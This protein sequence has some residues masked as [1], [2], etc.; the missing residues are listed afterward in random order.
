LE[1]YSNIDDIIGKY[2][3]GEASPEDAMF[4]EEWKSADPKQY[5][6]FQDLSALYNSKPQIA[7]SD[8]KVETA[9]ETLQTRIQF[10]PAKKPANKNVL[11]WGLAA[12]VLLVL[13]CTAVYLYFLKPTASLDYVALNTAISIKLEDK[14]EIEVFKNSSVSLEKAYNGTSR[15]MKLKGSAYFNVEH[16]V[17][18]PFIVSV[19]ELNIKD[20]GTK[21]K[22]VTSN[23]GD[24]IAISVDEG[25]VFLYDSLGFEK[26]IRANEKYVYILSEHTGLKIKSDAGH[27]VLKS[28]NFKNMSLKDLVIALNE[29]YKVP[30]TIENPKILD[31]K[32]TAQFKQESLENVLFIVAETLGLEIHKDEKGFTIT[33]NRCKD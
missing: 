21:F 33:G 11:Y 6:Y 17:Q 28:F 27:T 31:C 3:A 24:T 18:K 19:G 5:Q 13:G 20:I 26:T 25:E 2:L 10:I 23:N 12:S 15:K 8:R 22:I 30:I 29:A 14:T 7:I 1:N 32:I 16:D 4:L 9:W